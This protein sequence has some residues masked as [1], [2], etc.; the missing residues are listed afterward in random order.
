V[1]QV[2]RHLV[3]SPLEYK[4]KAKVDAWSKPWVLVLKTNAPKWEDVF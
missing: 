4:Q 3:V 1:V 2:T